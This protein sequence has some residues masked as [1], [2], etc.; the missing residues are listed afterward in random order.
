MNC[1]SILATPSA[2]FPCQTEGIPNEAGHPGKHSFKQAA[3][4]AF[5]EWTDEQAAEMAEEWAR[6]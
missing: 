6:V 4:N 5:V 2:I 1:P 3:P